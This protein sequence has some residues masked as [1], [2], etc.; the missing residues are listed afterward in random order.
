M[1]GWTDGTADDLKSFDVGD[2]GRLVADHLASSYQRSK[3]NVLSRS[4]V[5]SVPPPH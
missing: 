3:R 2:R 1:C 5:L 4:S